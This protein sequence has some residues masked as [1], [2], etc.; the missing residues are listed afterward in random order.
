MKRINK[1][2]LYV[3]LGF[4]GVIQVYPLLYLFFFSLKSNG[5]I[6]GGNI[7]GLPEK[8]LWSNYEVILSKS[9]MP[10]Y[11]FNSTLVT[12]ISILAIIVLGS[13]AAYAIQ[14]MKWK[15]SNLVLTIFLLG[16][17]IPTQSSLLPLFNAFSAVD[18]TNSY[19]ALIVPYISFGLPVAIYIFTGFYESIPLEMEESGCLEGCN[20]FQI[21]Y[22]II[23]PMVKPAVATIAIFSYRNIWNELLFAVTFISQRA[24]KTVPVGLMSLTG[25]YSTKWGPIGAGLLLAVLPSLILYLLLSKKVQES[26]MAGAIKG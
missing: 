3:F 10:L 5:E 6:F 9:D 19:I 21:Y 7:M 16:I 15:Y 8:W 11:F 24:F 23:L 22:Y 17:M 18:L 2:L 14:R 20:I 25:R 26:M 13:T 1:T 12:V 4:F